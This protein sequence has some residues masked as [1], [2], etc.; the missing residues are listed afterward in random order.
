MTYSF[1]AELVYKKEK[2]VVKKLFNQLSN[3]LIEVIDSTSS[4]LIFFQR[5]S[6]LLKTHFHNNFKNAMCKHVMV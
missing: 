4:Q 1:F 5:V 2:Q 3:I 6:K